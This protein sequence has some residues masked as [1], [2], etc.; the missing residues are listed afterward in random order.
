MTLSDAPDDKVVEAY[1]ILLSILATE[2]SSLL[3]GRS[4]SAKAS[5]AMRLFAEIEGEYARRGFRP[6]LPSCGLLPAAKPSDGGVFVLAVKRLPGEHPVFF[7]RAI[8]RSIEQ[9][10]SEVGAWSGNGNRLLD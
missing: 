9:K 8:R 6:L 10:I 5:K 3:A 2:R 7:A 4:E 1:F